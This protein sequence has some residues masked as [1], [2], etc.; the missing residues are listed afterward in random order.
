MKKYLPSEKLSDEYLASERDRLRKFVFSLFENPFE[1]EIRAVEKI[2]DRY[3]QLKECVQ[4]QDKMQKYVAREEYPKEIALQFLTVAEFGK[5]A[6]NRYF[7]EHREYT[8]VTF[9]ELANV[10]FKSFQC[11]VSE[12]KKYNP[13]ALKEPSLGMLA[14]ILEIKDKFFEK[15]PQWTK[16]VIRIEASKLSLEDKF[17][18][19]KPKT[20][21]EREFKEHLKTVIRN[22]I[23]DFWRLKIDPS[24][25][26]EG[27]ICFEK[28]LKPA[29]RKSYDWWHEKA[30]AF[31]PT[32]RS[33]LGTKSEYIA[34]LGVLMKKLVDGGLA[35]NAVW[36][37]VCN[38]SKQ[39]GHYWNSEN[40]KHKFEFTG[41]RKVYGFCDLA[42]TNKI[43]A[44]DEGAGGFW[45]ASGDYRNF[46]GWRPLADLGHN[47]NC[48]SNLDGS[49]GWLVLF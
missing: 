32:C 3:E 8:V 14:E 29:V 43:L 10:F 21:E 6:F 19:H 47:N 23:K 12:W 25:D 44:N 48:I 39:L 40:A 24:F 22:G 28:G 17:M 30:E 35:V 46:S 20:A 31:S 15:Y 1:E 38:D 26:S 49:V 33:R 45:V 34:F 41:S 36:N 7:E 5:D 9:Y 42:N 13:Y 18:K 4:L 11:G 27:N 16:Y 2:E 37:A